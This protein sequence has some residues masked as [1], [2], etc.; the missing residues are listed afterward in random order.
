MLNKE[1]RWAMNKA[2]F[3][4]R[5]GTINVDKHYVYKAEDFEF[6]PYAIEGLKLLQEEGFLL[7]VLTN[8]SGIARGYYTEKELRKLNYRKN[9]DCR[10]PALGMFE[11]AVLEFN[12]DLAQSYTIGDKLRDHAICDRSG[13][14]GYLVGKGEKQ[15][16]IDSVER[17]SGGRIKY[18]DDLYHCA[19]DILDK[20]YNGLSMRK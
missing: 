2:I 4:D 19:L 6:L 10:K 20:R 14:R 17:R 15:D 5:D 3:L 13:C 1:L 18:M 7:L 12:I 16:I 8:Q 9:C 11:R